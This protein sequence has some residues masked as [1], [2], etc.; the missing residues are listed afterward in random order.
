MPAA[1]AADHFARRRQC[2]VPRLERAQI[3][4]ALGTVDVQNPEPGDQA[5]R[6]CDVAI[7]LPP[8]TPDRL[9][10]GGCGVEAARDSRLLAAGHTGEDREPYGGIG[11]RGVS[12]NELVHSVPPEGPA[13]TLEKGGGR[14]ILAGAI[15]S[16]P[17]VT[18]PPAASDTSAA[19]YYALPI[20]ISFVGT[21]LWDRIVTRRRFTRAAR[22]IHLGSGFG[23]FGRGAVASARRS[24]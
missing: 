9:R 3:C 18:T 11:E 6:D 21:G 8:K 4:L 14:R 17:K 13:A 23:K 1:A 24:S 5:G 15:P 10:V 12:L 20:S 2:T 16:N 7:G 22:A 19:G